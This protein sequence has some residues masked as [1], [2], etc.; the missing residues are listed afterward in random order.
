VRDLH[1]TL[2]VEDIRRKVA[3]R[4]NSVEV[5]AELKAEGIHFRCQ[6]FTGLSETFAVL[7]SLIQ[8]I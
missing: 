8:S 7:I 2:G 6:F 1:D 4:R 5:R 3:K